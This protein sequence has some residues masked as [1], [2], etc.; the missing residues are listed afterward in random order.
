MVEIIKANLK[1]IK[2]IAELL[3]DYDVY[4][5][6]LDKRHKIDSIKEIIKFN[7]KV[8]KHPNVVFFVLVID[9]KI[10]GVVSG[11]D[12]KTAIEKTAIIHQIIV[13][14]KFRG[15]GYGTMLLS[16][17]E[18]YFKNRGCK[19]MKSFVFINNKR[20][21]KLYKKLDYKLEE[22]YSITKKLK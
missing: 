12:R 1:D 5:N 15:R 22:G 14:E 10:Q 4:E 11:E 20:S 6:K 21:A 2:R 18:E 13:S 19:F 8:I 3:H 9:G 7:K 16:E 17:I